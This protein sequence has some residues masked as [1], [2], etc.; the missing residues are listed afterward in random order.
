MLFRPL[1][2]LSLFA[3]ALANP[4]RRA[5]NLEV[6]VTGP[7]SSV[8]SI[9][10]LKF[11]AKVT[12]TG[13][14]AVK[15]LK[16]GTILDELPTRSFKVTKDG[17]ELKFTGIKM[18]VDLNEAVYTVIQPGQTI[19]TVHDVAQLYDFESAGA[20]KFTFEALT[21]FPTE[22]D[23]SL[24][25]VQ[26]PTTAVEV[27]VT[28]DV[29]QRQIQPVNKRST[30][31]CTNASMKS[32]IDA[33]YSEARSLASI[34]SSYISS[35]GASDSLFRA[36]YG[37]N[38]ASSVSTIFNRVASGGSSTLNC[39]DALGACTSGVI[40]YT[41]VSTGNI[42]FCSIFYNEVTSSRLCSGTSV[43]SR[44]VRGGTVLHELTHATSGTDDITYGCSADQALSNSQK[45]D[46][47][48]NFNCFSTQ[49]YQNTQ[50]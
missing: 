23:S 32:F 7:S 3:I 44:N 36:Y 33:A 18:S 19:T 22:I 41:L 30:D 27:E 35:S 34:S 31:V 24:S 1:V 25:K 4:I 16:Y 5:E 28:D 38:S 13:A 39:Q 37:T 12:N 8:K 47:A 10:D 15:V 20:G 43:A 40:A 11:T 45:I 49:V 42:Y 26:A 48:D 9:D 29:A 2:A 6:S 14:E 21:A 50:C 17:Q 46:N